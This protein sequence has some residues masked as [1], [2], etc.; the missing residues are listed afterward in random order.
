M[1][2]QETLRSVV[3]SLT[4]GM[5][6]DLA[7]KVEVFDA[8]GAAS[9]SVQVGDREITLTKDN[10]PLLKIYIAEAG[11]YGPPRPTGQYAPKDSFIPVAGC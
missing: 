2:Q 6:V 9:N 7:A 10:A 5:L 11:K 3:E 4:S 1:Q 8:T